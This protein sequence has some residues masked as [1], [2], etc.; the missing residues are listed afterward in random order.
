MQMTQFI[1]MVASRDPVRGAE[2]S[3]LYGIRDRIEQV[4]LA[5][6]IADVL[7]LFGLLAL[8]ARL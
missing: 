4:T 8:S 1:D 7:L 2:L 5:L 6:V 3:L